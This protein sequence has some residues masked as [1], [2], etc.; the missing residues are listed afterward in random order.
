M[1][2]EKVKMI[3]IY[4]NEISGNTERDEITK[5]INNNTSKIF[6]L[7]FYGNGDSCIE[8]LIQKKGER[9]KKSFGTEKLFEKSFSVEL[10]ASPKKFFRHL[11]LFAKRNNTIINLLPL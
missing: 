8:F 5:F 6:L 10:M 7:E 1:K 3:K 9:E 2:L 4:T 11:H